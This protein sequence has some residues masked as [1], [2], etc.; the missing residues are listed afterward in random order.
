MTNIEGYRNQQNMISLSKGD[1]YYL[2]N[3]KYLLFFARENY[4]EKSTSLLSM[5]FF[6]VTVS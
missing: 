1:I 5:N 3:N 4:I 2:R 6:N